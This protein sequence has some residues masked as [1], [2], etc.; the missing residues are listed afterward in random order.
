MFPI[1]M[2]KYLEY[3]HAD[4][5]T[6]EDLNFPADKDET[7]KVVRRD[8]TIT[9]ESRQRCKIVTHLHQV[10][11]RADILRTLDSEKERKSQDKIDLLQI[12][13]DQNAACEKNICHLLGK[14]NV[15]SEYIKEVTHEILYKCAVDD[16]K[17]FILART[18]DI[19]KSKLPKRGKIGD[20]IQGERNLLKMAYDLREA[21]NLLHDEM[22]S[23]TKEQTTLTNQLPVLIRHHQVEVTTNNR[24]T[25]LASQ[26][27]EDQLG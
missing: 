18:N 13:I 27:L 16:L 24:S 19:T 20:A 7:G 22:Q 15:Q 21:P 12:K 2:D 23:I 14:D 26:L 8:A 25:I 6:F 9:Q 5:G 1:L 10:E 4:D 17:S 11:L 3:G